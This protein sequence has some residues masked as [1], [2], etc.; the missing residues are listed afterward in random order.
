MPTPANP[1]PLPFPVVHTALA[2]VLKGRAHGAV[3]ALTPA[4]LS[5]A[6]QIATAARQREGVLLTGTRHLSPQGASWQRA[7]KR[8]LGAAAVAAE[9]AEWERLVALTHK[10]QVTPEAREMLKRGAPAYTIHVGWGDGIDRPITLRHERKVVLRGWVMGLRRNASD[11]TVL[12]ACAEATR[13]FKFKRG[14]VIRY[15]IDRP[16]R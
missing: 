13:E 10:P 5:K 4:E 12:A 2:V 9:A 11:D 16:A 6:I 7:K 8:E 1:A 14:S 15:A 3:R